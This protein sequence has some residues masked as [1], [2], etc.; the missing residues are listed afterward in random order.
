MI[1]AAAWE[2]KDLPLATAEQPL[3]AISISRTPVGLLRRRTISKSRKSNACL[4]SIGLYPLKYFEPWGL[5]KADRKFIM[6]LKITEI[7][8]RKS[9]AYPKRKKREWI[10]MKQII[11]SLYRQIGNV[12]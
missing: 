6:A 2:A 10:D 8:L 4:V 12:D 1:G 9:Q 5:S 11:F 3:E 7:K